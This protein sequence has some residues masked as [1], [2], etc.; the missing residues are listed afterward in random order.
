MAEA[1]VAR[2]ITNSRKTREM[3]ALLTLKLEDGE[4]LKDY[5]TRFWETYNDID[6]C[7][8]DVAIRTFKL[9]L[10]LG[11]GLRQSLTKRP[12]ATLR[13]MMDRIEQFIRVEEDGGNT[14]SVQMVA[15][16]KAA[17]SKP[18]ARFSISAKASL[19][20]SNFMAPLFRAFQTVFKEPIYKVMNN[21][22]GKPY[23][24]WPPK[25]LGNPA[26][27]DQKLQCSYHRDK[28]HLTENCHMLKTHL[29][30]LALAGHLNQYIDTNLSGK[31]ESSSVDRH[32]SNPGAAST[33]VINVIHN[34]LCSSILPSSYR[35]EIQKATHLRW[36]FVIN[37]SAHPALSR[38]SHENSWEHAISFSNSD[39]RD[40]QLPYNDPLVVTLSIGNFD[41]KR[42]LIDQRSFTEVMYQ[43]LYKKFGLGES[44]LTSF[45]S[46]VFGFRGV[47]RTSGRNYSASSGR[48][49]HPPDPIYNGY[50]CLVGLRSSKVSPDLACHALN[51][52]PNHKPVA[53]KRRKLALERANIV[54]EEVERLLAA[55][56]ILEVQY[57]TWLSNTVVVKKKN[58]KWRMCVDFTNLIRACPKDS[59]P[60]PRIDQLVDSASG[61][62]RLSFLDAFQ[63]Y[64][65]IPMNL[66]DQ[67]KTA[68]I[69][70]RGA[71]CYK[72]IDLKNARA[73]YQRMVTQIDQTFQRESLSG[74]VQL[75]LFGIEYMPRTVIKGQVLADF[76]AEFQQDPC[77]PTLAI[78]TETQFNLGSGK[79]EV[80]IDRASNFKGLGAGIVLVS[81]KGLI[82]EQAIGREHNSH[83]EILAKLATALE[84]DIQ[85]T[86]CV[87]TLDCPSF[88]CREVLSIHAA[89]DQS[90]WMDP[91]L[92]YLKNN[93]LPEDR[94]EADLIKRKALKYWSCGGD[95]WLIKR[96]PRDTGGHICKLMRSV[97]PLPKAPRNKRFFIVTIDYFT[98]WIKAELLS[99]IQDVNTK[100]FLWKSVIT[101]FGVPW[102]II[103][104]NGTQ[105]ESRLFTGFC[106]GLG[107]KNFFSSPAYPQSNGQ[108][109]VSNEVI[110]DGV[111][112]RLEEAKG[113]WVEELPSVMWTHRTTKRRS[114]E[115][116]PFALA[117]RVEA[118]IP[119]RLGCR[120]SE[121]RI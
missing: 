28:G 59:Y 66:A 80:F 11:T 12:A 18:L 48:T 67:E 92:D 60:L 61:H 119:W 79:W 16:P 114:T 98:K 7:N 35:S 94:K 10:P 52:V 111:K 101:W 76:V 5:A 113:R 107:I 104:D 78:P 26:S 44:D 81:P 58:E 118:V 32:P 110:L 49:D 100:R 93:K 95:P 20:P 102:T 1:F 97:G 22:K 62:D 120:L 89:N 13:K 112:K 99:N 45:T 96:Y 82:L 115:E 50:F 117:Y 25:L 43:D 65:Q 56:T 69:T 21:I 72:V 9:G 91:I 75:G 63:G 54:L 37:D 121:P 23:F 47:Y 38:S 17:S 14:S 83:A 103:S 34:P 109:E 40:V 53:Q 4:S 105:F 84:S 64:H 87:E 29:E 77:A 108:T 85:R 88:Q 36:S 116:T 31:R 71:Y 57:P 86:I 15:P 2:F 3:D 39:L 8:E 27:K 19:S 106:S 42:V 41:V 74:G 90:S 70:P 30:Q 55:G 73:T 46:P 68:F 51:I 24:V 6:G 33:G